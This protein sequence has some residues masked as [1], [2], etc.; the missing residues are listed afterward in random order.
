MISIFKGDT[1]PAKL[2]LQRPD[3]P[4]EVLSA[5][6]KAGNNAL[7]AAFKMG[8]SGVVK[9]ILERDNLPKEVLESIMPEPD[10]IKFVLSLKSSKIINLVLKHRTKLTFIDR[11]R[12][13]FAGHFR[14]AFK[15]NCPKSIDKT[16]HDARRSMTLRTYNPPSRSPS[17]KVS[18]SDKTPLLPKPGA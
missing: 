18:S 5:K 16:Q 6:N 10:L 9:A 14:L 11:L 1:D 17:Q 4:G 3:L 12:L 8:Y 15:A 13:F 7:M 2:I